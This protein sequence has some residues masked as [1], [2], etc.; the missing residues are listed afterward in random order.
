MHRLTIA[1]NRGVQNDLLYPRRV[2]FH[3]E[4][5]PLEN[6]VEDHEATCGIPLGENGYKNCSRPPQHEGVHAG[7]IYDR[8][9]HYRADDPTVRTFNHCGTCHRELTDEIRATGVASALYCVDH[10][11]PPQA[12]W[13]RRND[14]PKCG[15]DGPYEMRNFSQIS[16]MGDLHCGR[17]GAYIRMYDPT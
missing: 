3:N 17:C 15:Y 6:E 12:E 5:M 9:F 11:G 13:H 7:T 10:I 14:C 4:T 2:P 16:R 1:E 8:T